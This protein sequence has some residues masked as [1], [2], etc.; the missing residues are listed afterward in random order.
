MFIL[1]TPFYNHYL[2]RFFYTHVTHKTNGNYISECSK[3][4]PKEN[5]TLHDKVGEVIH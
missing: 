5:K 4:A 1:S 3:L 2:Y